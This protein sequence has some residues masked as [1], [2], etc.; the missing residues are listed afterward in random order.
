MNQQHLNGT[1]PGGKPR[2]HGN[3]FDSI[4]RYTGPS[5]FNKDRAFSAANS[6][7][8]DAS[9]RASRAR[10]GRELAGVETS[11]TGMREVVDKNER[12]ERFSAFTNLERGAT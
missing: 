2:S 12:R 9:A 8:M 5:I 1:W 3:A 4:Y 11:L 7:G 6:E 10:E